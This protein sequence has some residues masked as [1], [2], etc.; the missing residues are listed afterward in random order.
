MYFALKIARSEVVAVKTFQIPWLSK[1]IQIIA[2]HT[3]EIY[4]VHMTISPVI[5]DMQM[6]FPFNFIIFIIAT[7]TLSRL[8]KILSE[9]IFIKNPNFA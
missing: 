6:R 2:D 4:I 1:T 8:V 5:L 3:L 7:F 9:K